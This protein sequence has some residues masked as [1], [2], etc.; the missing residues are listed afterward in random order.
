MMEA[1]RYIQE[2]VIGSHNYTA[3]VEIN[4]ATGAQWKFCILRDGT[5]IAGPEG[6][7]PQF[8]CEE[9]DIKEKAHQCAYMDAGINDHF[10]DGNCVPWKRDL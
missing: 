10:C 6:C 1:Q 2:L 4:I 7:G 9:A 8:S 3:I 5:K